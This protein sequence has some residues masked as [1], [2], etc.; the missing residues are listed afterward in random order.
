[1][2]TVWIKKG[3]HKM[4]AKRAASLVLAVLMTAVLFGCNSGAA[5]ATDVLSQRVPQEG[6]TPITVLVK[7]AFTIEAFEQAVEEKFP[8]IDIIQVGN[9]TSNMGIAEY[10]ARM[11]HD[12]LTDIV[13]TWP[14]DVGEEYWADR[15]I[16]LSPLPLTEKYV[17][18][19]LDPISR[20]GKLYYLP[21]PSQLRGILYNKTLFKEKGWEVPNDFEG[22]LALCTE[23][24]KSGIRAL[25]LGLGNEEVLDT[26]FVGFGYNES[27]STPQNAQWI[28]QYN[29]GEGQFS[30]NFKP[31]LDTFQTLITSGV[32]QPGDL[33]LTYT[34]RERM[35]FNREC[36]MVE[37][38]VLLARM[39]FD[40]NGCTDEFGLMPFFNPGEDGDWVRLYQVC[41]IGL[42]KKLEQP[43]NKEKLALC[44]Q[45]L[46]YISTQE[47]QEALAGDTG[48][49]FSAVKDVPPPDIPEID[50]LLHTLDAG[51]YTVFSPL[52]NAQSAL[53]K[54]LAG[55]VA[56]TMTADD[57]A[58][59]VDAENATP[60]V[61]AAPEVL[62]HATADFSLIETG[63]FVTDVMCA[64]S[65]CEIALFL[66]NGKDGESNGQGISGKL[67]KG[68]LTQ[69][70]IGRILP[71]FRM[72]EKGELLKVTMRGED[73]LRVLEYSIPIN[74][75]NT[76]WF[77]YFSGLK[78]EYAPSDEPGNRI[79]RISLA[80]G[81]KIDPAHIDSV[82][83]MG[84]SAIDPAR[85][86]SVAVIEGSVPADSVQTTE[87]TGLFI[88]DLLQ[89][90]I[91]DQK[92]ISPANDGRFIPVQPNF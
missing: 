75:N 59:M 17:N 38:S 50:D 12:D 77:Y 91:L 11:Q 43:E 44:M 8:E 39:G 3:A 81:S 52:E 90:A 25:Q 82:A 31:A 18:S 9:H 78:M 24:E 70:D 56:G 83:V 5:Q 61:A 71:D 36:A 41:F 19:M 7:N 29:A 35:L 42:N 54:G 33:D 48:A 4:L 34:D 51:R 84:Q 87:F 30:D 68:E 37:D 69:A 64:Q 79:K 53:R 22:F 73:L 6:R 65:G 46:E 66:D 10:E 60:A 23:I 76:G 72:D 80:D 92:E 57:V 32:L 49:M 2:Q 62:G 28:A 13:M 47:G 26:A 55:M 14:L 89:Q 67:Y 85:D 20:D 15:L 40:Y 74:N 88:S 21:G 45:L 1:M 27:F 58:T 63:N 16:D 86:Y